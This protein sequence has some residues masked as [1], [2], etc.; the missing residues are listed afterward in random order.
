M[1]RRDEAADHL[2]ILQKK[3][4]SLR[5]GTRTQA[6][7]DFFLSYVDIQDVV[8]SDPGAILIVPGAQILMSLNV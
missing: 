8:L 3:Q 6:I 1:F 5:I 2:Q 7:C 4:V